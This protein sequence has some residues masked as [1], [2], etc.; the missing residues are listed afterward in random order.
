MNE[1]E[2][3]TNPVLVAITA[4]PG[5]CFWR[6]NAGIFLTLDGKRHIRSNANG[7][8]DIIGGY[9]G[10]GVAI[11][12]K[13]KTGRLRVSQQNFRTAWERAGCIYIVARCPDDALAILA[14][15]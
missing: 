8:A 12:T 13:T 9:R 7:V 10:R 3:V 5:A 14:S 15:L 4:L 11:E 1:R 2:D 6:A